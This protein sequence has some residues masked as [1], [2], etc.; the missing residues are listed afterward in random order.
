V[1]AETGVAPGERL[2]VSTEAGAI[3]LP[4]VVTAM[5]DRVVWL[6]TNSPGSAVRATLRADV[7]SIVRLS[8]AEG[9]TP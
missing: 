1:A 7:G 9:S 8:R 4:L 3:S 5:A 6:P 2:R